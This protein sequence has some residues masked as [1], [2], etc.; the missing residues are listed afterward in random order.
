MS[1]SRRSDSELL[2]ASRAG[3]ME[4]FG[5]FY[6]RYREVLLG[7]LVRR[8]RRAELAADVMAEAFARALLVVKDDRAE[9]PQAP[10]AWLFAVAMNLVRDSARSNRVEM[11]ARARL[12]L[13][14]L[15][16]GDDDIDRILEIAAAHDLARDV[17]EHVSELEW[18]ALSAR[19]ID[20]Q[21]YAVIAEQLRCS[22]AVVRK[23]VSRARSQLRAAMGGPDA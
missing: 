18:E 22:Q 23:R 7:H 16:L 3:D 14:R 6:V 4:A 9:L 5:E 8:L 13:E 17:R 19:V 20:E 11:T 21:P 15:V 10:A 1:V 12:G 2:G